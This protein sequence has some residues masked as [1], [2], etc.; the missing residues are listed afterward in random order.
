MINS[1]SPEYSNVDMTLDVY[2]NTLHLMFNREP[3]V[4]LLD[5]AQHLTSVA[6]YVTDD[7]FAYFSS[8][9]F[10]SS[11]PPPTEAPTTQR[12]NT[13]LKVQYYHK[14]KKSGYCEYA[15]A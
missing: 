8:S 13:F 2:F 6:A 12:A 4:K 10:T 11:A 7:L 14:C 1:D 15:N 5:F 3:I 9:L